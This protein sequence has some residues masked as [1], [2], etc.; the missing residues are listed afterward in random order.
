MTIFYILFF[1]CINFIIYRLIKI[2][3]TVK[4]KFILILS[5]LIFDVIF[6]K[7]YIFLQNKFADSLLIKPFGM[8]V[9][10]TFSIMIPIIIYLKRLTSKRLKS[11]IENNEN[12]MTNFG[13]ISDETYTIIVIT[14]ITF[15][16]VLF[17]WSGIVNSFK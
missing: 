2:S 17:L 7:S 10:I 11:H 14:T 6:T 1:L 8:F 4:S 12:L 3:K 5:L 13:I 15:L 9:L 16:Q